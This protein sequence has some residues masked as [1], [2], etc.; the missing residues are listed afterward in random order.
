MNRE[1]GNLIFIKDSD[2]GRDTE[3]FIK[4][5]LDRDE[6]LKWAYILH[7]K[8]IYNEHDMNA[9]RYGAQYCW[10]DGFLGMEKYSSKEEY[11]DEQMKLP[12]FIGDR[13][14]AI[15]VVLAITDRERNKETVA[16]WFNKQFY[17]IRRAVDQTEIIEQLKELTQED[18]GSRL[19][20]K[21]LYPDDEV[22]ANFDFRAYIDNP[23]KENKRLKRLKDIFIPRHIYE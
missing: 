1:R 7:D 17:E 15:W 21:Y 23:P 9:R 19:L 4:A 8:D 14:T 6:I 12:P 11:I 3:T 13:K 16:G 5:A 2:Y 20:E 22:K 18:K 10:A